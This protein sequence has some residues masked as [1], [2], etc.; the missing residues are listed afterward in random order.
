[1]NKKPIKLLSDDQLKP[2]VDF[3]IISM[4]TIISFNR[5]HLNE[6]NGKIINMLNMYEVKLTD[7]LIVH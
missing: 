3:K 5:D 6:A 7:N 1:M 4:W 2:E